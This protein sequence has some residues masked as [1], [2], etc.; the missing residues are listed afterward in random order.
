MG[1][2][3]KLKRILARDTLEA[4]MR[5]AI[6]LISAL[7][8]TPIFAADPL[9]AFYYTG[10]PLSFISGGKTATLTPAGGYTF[11][12]SV[13]VDDTNM[14]HG[15]SI[16]ANNSATIDSWDAG[17]V[18]PQGQ[19]LGVGTY[20]NAMQTGS[21]T[22]SA[23]G[24][25]FSGGFKG[26]DQSTGFFTILEITVSNGTLISFAAD[27]TQYDE[28]AQA[29]WN[30]GSIR[31]NSSIPL[32]VLPP[33]PPQPLSL[34]CTEANGPVVKS[35]IYTYSSTCFAGGGVG[36][37][38]WSIVNG[39]LPAGLNM[40]TTFPPGPG[41]ITISGQPASAGPFSYTLQVTDSQNH[42]ASQ[43][44]AG[45]TASTACVPSGTFRTI[46][47]TY[48]FAP[49]GGVAFL[50]FHFISEGCPWTLTADIPGVTFSRPSGITQAF[51]PDITSIASVPPNPDPTPRRGNLI[52]RESGTIVFTFPV[53]VNSTA[54]TYAINPTSAHFGADGGSGT[55][56]VT[57][58]PDGCSA[59]QTGSTS[60]T[61]DGGLY[62]YGI[63]PNTGPAKTGTFSFG[64]G[65]PGAQQAVLSWDQD[66]GNGSFVVG[67]FAQGAAKVGMPIARCAVAGGMEPYFWSISEGL[68]PGG[69]PPNTTGPG[70]YV[71][72]PAVPGPYRFTVKATDSSVPTP[73]VTTY[74]EVGTILAMPPRISCSSTNGPPQVGIPY[75]VACLAAAG[76]PPY[77]WSV[78]AGTLPAGLQLTPLSNG[79]VSISGTPLAAGNYNYALQLTDSTT[80]IAMTAA[81][82]F[83]GATASAGSTAALFSMTCA[84]P[85]LPSEIGTPMSP[86][87]CAAS[88][89][90]PP[91][92]WS[93]HTGVLPPG[94]AFSSTTGN[95]I[96]ISGTPTQTAIGGSFDVYLK[97]T[98]SSVVPQ[99]RL[100]ELNL[101]VSNQLSLSCSPAS[102]QV[103]QAYLSACSIGASGWIS[104][105]IL[106]PGLTLSPTGISGTPTTPGTYNFTISIQDTS[107]PAPVTVS[108]PYTITIDPLPPPLNTSLVS[109]SMAH[110]AVGDGWQS[111]TVLVNPRSTFAQ[112]HVGYYVDDGSAL[113]IPLLTSPPGT[114]ATTSSVDQIMPAGSVLTV[115]SQAPAA[116][117]LAVGSAEVAADSGVSGYIRFR[118]NPR[119]QDALVPLETR[120]AAAY[121][122]AFDNTSGIATGT[123]VAN[124]A[125]SPANIAVVIRDDSGAQIGSASISLPAQ[126]HVSFVMSDRFANTANRSGTLEFD[127][128]LN[129]RIS[130]LG[131][132][133]P[134][135]QRFTTIPVIASTDAGGGALAHL[136]VGDGWESTIELVNAGATTAQAHLK[137]FADDGS[138]LPIQV[139]TGGTPALVS[140]TDQTLAPHQR[141]VIDSTA[142]AG[143]PLQIGSA[144][145]ATDGQVSGFIRFRYG[146][147]DEEAIVPLETRNA[148]AYILPFDNLNGVA[149]GVSV[150]NLSNASATIPVVIRDSVG[151]MIGSDHVTLAGNGHSAFVL[152][153]QFLATG[154]QTGSVEFDTPAGGKISVLGIRFAPSGVFST[155]PVVTP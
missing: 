2:P 145:L 80:P 151:N 61:V 65:A 132:R 24:L 1:L 55:F 43:S 135:G 23:P 142:P 76:T 84:L 108:N 119:D 147:R 53:V 25:S 10:S 74:T 90:T 8:A 126:G 117:A 31:Y 110:L 47:Q 85:N 46:P 41:S 22:P 88:G 16:E 125:N 120:Q 45:T 102:G 36:P 101:H 81:E 155:I 57:S 13:G 131:L 97:V 70:I 42:T 136:A 29:S 21:Q 105:G 134:P 113:S 14:L 95:V 12:V 68:V 100:W 48:A 107:L 116:A 4:K 87:A 79:A 63:P 129:G 91:Y 40:Q 5:S 11:F 38:Q 148:S 143:A 124:L 26:D 69:F 96:S 9:T 115:D 144:Q 106:P 44:F 154:N 152:A 128:P 75:A 28:G 150:A 127:T 153:S 104:A 146:P 27:F 67:C 133:F 83:T 19:I 98:D 71:G 32:N 93:I 66:A 103:G 86:I 73:Q 138:G 121:T 34:A 89:G 149:T 35:V 51:G 118:Y 141:F 60:A 123:A 82:S 111:T 62:Y 6:I 64:S 109:G 140:A 18:A 17:F 122:L 99:P 72:N 78:A 114:T 39:Q 30:Y 137:F 130:V 56:T 49:S 33:V 59:A 50:S 139:T 52:L 7:F 77:Q 92:N 112:A 15:V 20:Q 37:F 54:C 3:L 58:N 94:M